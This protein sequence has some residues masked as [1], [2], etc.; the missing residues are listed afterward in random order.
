MH[1]FSYLRLAGAALLLA[2]G[3][4]TGSYNYL[5]EETETHTWPTIGK[6]VFGAGTV[7]GNISVANTSNES[8]KAVVIKSCTGQSKADATDYMDNIEVTYIV[9]G[10]EIVLSAD[11]PEEGKREYSAD[12]EVTIPASMALDLETVNG[13]VKTEG[14]T[15][16]AS[17]NVVNGDI[18][19]TLPADVSAQFEASTD[20]GKV[21]VIGFGS[22]SYY[23]DEATHK[24]G[25]IGQGEASIVLAAT[26]GDIIIRAE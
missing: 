12:I 13:R 19:M 21:E 1:S 20:N 18:E 3:C 11:M 15:G 9:D 5:L 22:A 6:D 16:D 2:L 17:I 10:N 14:T 25:T 7:N 4:D 26:N 24:V 8:V 23:I